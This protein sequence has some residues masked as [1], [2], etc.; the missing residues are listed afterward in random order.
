MPFLL[1]Q[2]VSQGQ[3]TNY[4]GIRRSQ[5]DAVRNT[6]PECRIPRQFEYSASS[7]RRSEKKS[8]RFW[9]ATS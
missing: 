5:S 7:A 4:D 2:Y 3:L 1:L 6:R 8:P 9:R